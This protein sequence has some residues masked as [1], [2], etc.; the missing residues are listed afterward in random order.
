MVLGN[1]EFDH[2]R[3]VL[4]EQMNL[5]K[6]PFLSANV[7]DLNGALLAVPYIIKQFSGF[8]VAVFGLTTTESKI[9]AN[10]DHIKDLIFEDEVAVAKKLVPYL[11]E[12]ADVVI[13]LAH[14]GIYEGRN[15]GSKRLAAQVSGIDLIVDGNTD[16]KMEV[17]L[18][19]T[20]PDSTH[21]T[22]IVQAWHWG[23]VLGRIDLWIRDKRVVD[24]K[25]EMIPIN[26]KRA[27][28]KPNGEK[29]FHFIGKPIREHPGLSALLK[30]YAEKVDLFLDERIGYAKGAF[31]NDHGRFRETALGRPGRRCHALVHEAFQPGFCVDQQRRHPVRHF[32]RAID[33]GSHL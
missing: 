7:K 16:T 31:D 27:V 15:R 24:F 29:A 26:L 23:L 21:Q 22:L 30:P 25:M 3:H 13:A 4:K 33:P 20:D 10:P 14:L 9:T 1:H 19:V 6:F 8:K 17:P 18:I 32:R 28:K 11:R 2:P 12:H 5:A